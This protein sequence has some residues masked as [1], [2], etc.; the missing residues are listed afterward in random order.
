MYTCGAAM[1]QP[2]CP[3][4]P[5]HS[6]LTRPVPHVP[7]APHSHA[8]YHPGI[9]YVVLCCAHAVAPVA[10][11][12]H[13]GAGSL[14]VWQLHAEPH[15]VLLRRCGVPC[16]LLWLGADL[17]PRVSRCAWG[18]RVGVGGVEAHMLEPRSHMPAHAS[19]VVLGFILCVAV[20]LCAAGCGDLGGLLAGPGG[21]GIC[22]CI[23]AGVCVAAPTCPLTFA[24]SCGQLACNGLRSCMAA[25]AVACRTLTCACP[26]ALLR[27]RG[28]RLPGS[29]GG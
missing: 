23:A 2:I 18:E 6:L 15:L 28:G 21:P 9:P 13:D 22:K 20:I 12:R 11:V 19:H 14:R 5:T 3:H 8:Q 1:A 7:R 16:R 26:P 10:A 17:Q 29:G 25:C 24:A 4:M 27:R